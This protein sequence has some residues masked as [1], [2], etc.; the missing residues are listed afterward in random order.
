M[1]LRPV[2]P[3]ALALLSPACA[4]T[5]PAPSAPLVAPAEPAEPDPD[6][7]LPDEALS[8]SATHAGPTAGEV[9]P[10][11]ATLTWY[12]GAPPAAGEPYVLFFWGTWCKPC[13]AAL[14]TLMARAAAGGLPI[15]AVSR[16]T[17]SGLDAFFAHW[18]AP[19]PERVAIE[20]G[21]YPVHNAYRA[22]TVPRFYFIDGA[23]R[24]T[25]VVYG[26]R[27]LDAL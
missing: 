27:D 17:P 16:D 1:Q 20:R 19:F 2:L 6:D 8:A 11:L 26:T 3:A 14:P 24:I 21:P 5:A 25:K 18:T 12:R 22:W 4:T 7:A 13:K 15:V 10:S 9:A 23:G